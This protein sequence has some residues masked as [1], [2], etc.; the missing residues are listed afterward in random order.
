MNP[1]VNFSPTGM[2]QGS[3]RVRATGPG[4]F[5]PGEVRRALPQTIARK[6]LSDQL[7]FPFYFW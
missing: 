5:L 3:R 6:R 1:R 2:A 7:D 4:G